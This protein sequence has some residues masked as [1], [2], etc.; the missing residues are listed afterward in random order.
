MN[1]YDGM[2]HEVPELFDQNFI[3]EE[4]LVLLKY[5]LTQT[6]NYQSAA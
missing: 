1:V 3:F 5:K 2:F 4:A 6:M